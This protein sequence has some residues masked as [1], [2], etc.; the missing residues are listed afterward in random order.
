MDAILKESIEDVPKESLCGGDLESDSPPSPVVNQTQQRLADSPVKA[1]SEA[2]VVDICQQRSKGSAKMKRRA[3]ASGKAGSVRNGDVSP[4]EEAKEEAVRQNIIDTLKSCNGCLSTVERFNLI[5]QDLRNLGWRFAATTKLNATWVYKAPGG[6][7]WW[8]E[9]EAAVVVQRTL[10]DDVV[11]L[12]ASPKRGRRPYGADKN[13]TDNDSSPEDEGTRSSPVDLSSPAGEVEKGDEDAPLY[14]PDWKVGDPWKLNPVLASILFALREEGINDM[15]KVFNEL[16]RVLNK[17]FGWGYKNGKMTW[18]YHTPSNTTDR[19]TDVEWA[20]AILEESIAHI[21]EDHLKR[22]WEDV[23]ESEVEDN[24]SES[25][26]E[27]N[28]SK[29]EGD[30]NE[31]MHHGS[32]TTDLGRED[33]EDDNATLTMDREHSLTSD[34]IFHSDAWIV[35]PSLLSIVPPNYE[36]SSQQSLEGVF[37][38]MWTSGLSETWKEKRGSRSVSTYQ[39]PGMESCRKYF[40][41]FHC[42][43]SILEHQQNV[44]VVQDMNA[45]NYVEDVTPP[46]SCSWKP[47]DL[48]RDHPEIREHMPSSEDAP[49]DDEIK[50]KIF[51]KIWKCLRSLKWRHKT[52]RSVLR[53][54]DYRPPDRKD[55]ISEVDAM[56]LILYQTPLIPEIQPPLVSEVGT[57]DDGSSDGCQPDLRYW[58]HLGGK[59]EFESGGTFTESGAYISSNKCDIATEMPIVAKDA[60]VPVEASLMI[61]RD[62]SFFSESV[63]K[64]ESR[65][66]VSSRVGVLAIPG[67]REVREE[68]VQHE[69]QAEGS[70]PRSLRVMDNAESPGLKPHVAFKPKKNSQNNLE[71]SKAQLLGTQKAKARAQRQ[72]KPETDAKIADMTPMEA[73]IEI[74]VDFDKTTKGKTTVERFNGIFAQLKVLGW[75][76]KSSSRLDTDWVYNP[77]EETGWL[78]PEE[79]ASIIQKKLPLQI[80]LVVSENSENTKCRRRKV[81]QKIT[82]PKIAKNKANR[83]INHKTNRKLDYHEVEQKVE[84]V[85]D[86]SSDE[87][88][89][90]TPRPRKTPV[91]ACDAASPPNDTVKSP[92]HDVKR[93]INQILTEFSAD[94]ITATRWNRIYGDLK[95][96]GWKHKSSTSILTDGYVY[97]VPNDGKWG[98]AGGKWLP[99]QKAAE[100]VQNAIID[101]G[102]VLLKDDEE[103]SRKRVR[104]QANVDVPATARDK[105]KSKSKS[106][107]GAGPTKKGVLKSGIG[108]GPK[109]KKRKRAKAAAAADATAETSRSGAKK[110][111]VA[112]KSTGCETSARESLKSAMNFLHPSSAPS[113]DLLCESRRE[114][115]LEIESFLGELEKTGRGSSLYLSGCPGSGKTATIDSVMKTFLSTHNS[116]ASL[117]VHPST[118]A[119]FSAVYI[120][121]MGLHDARDIFQEVLSCVHTSGQAS[122]SWKGIASEPT[123]YEDFSKM[124]HLSVSQAMEE[125]EDLIAPS[126]PTSTHSKG[127]PM[128]LLI[129]DEIDQLLSSGGAGTTHL[130]KLF[131]WSKRDTSTFALIGIANSIDL[132]DRFLPQLTRLECEPS[133]VVFPPYNFRE[134]TDM[135]TDRIGGATVRK[136]PLFDRGAIELCARKVAAIA[137]DARKALD[138]CRQ[139]LQ[140]SYSSINDNIS[141]LV[142]SRPRGLISIPQ[143][144]SALKRCLGSP[145]V[146]LIQGLPL[147]SKVLMCCATKLGSCIKDDNVFAIGKLESLY[148]LAAKEQ[149]HLDFSYTSF[150]ECLVQ[151]ANAGL[152]Q[153]GILLH[154]GYLCYLLLIL[155]PLSLLPSPFPSGCQGRSEQ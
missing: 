19:R 149:F 30:D 154:L 9:E 32:E 119:R 133:V 97:C 3:G 49:F 55:F 79:A 43:Q 34:E 120:N 39:P 115:R 28:A 26:G 108:Q 29:S 76:A 118:E 69:P 50:T 106:T 135:L 126:E 83:K 147:H 124:A 141:A 15:A 46:T 131:E 153:L 21:P 74:L 144:N 1:G 6:D 65:R 100:V 105:V 20:K 94:D 59:L 73:I 64:T 87:D 98:D 61:I 54:W 56:N 44:F 71:L 143:M 111:K 25:E 17:D 24:T 136:V 125:L 116:A 128:L 42:M 47:G 110:R 90:A 103:M 67:F 130:Q 38:E 27:D 101:K 75:T 4:K 63:K 7:D 107:A 14:M 139:A 84:T 77:P 53:D 93:A 140:I 52:S 78:T 134:L 10:P 62:E 80:T 152:V 5:R 11:L 41:A 8:T 2:K 145:H 92:G 22:G 112:E 16:Y 89:D 146:D 13:K 51:N 129:V 60:K 142:K 95:I 148:G 40:T 33:A 99:V 23:S 18:V 57:S 31:N 85:E 88:R 66:A 123:D 72:R 138:V 109:P 91:E 48:W 12:N 137:G 36:N 151:L 127:R 132:T 102:V 155:T 117:D 70:R 81:L 58:R 150:R 122:Y 86:N 104:T 113:E 37:D 96:L 35:P 82:P 114:Q 121:L 45:S 68:L